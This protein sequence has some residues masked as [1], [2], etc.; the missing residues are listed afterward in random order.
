MST[1]RPRSPSVRGL[2]YR[3]GDG[4]HPDRKGVRVRRAA[5]AV[6]AGSAA[7]TRRLGQSRH[8]VRVFRRDQ[9]DKRRARTPL[10]VTG[11]KSPDARPVWCRMAGEAGRARPAGSGSRPGRMSHSDRSDARSTSARTSGGRPLVATP[12]R[13]RPSGR[14]PS[15]GEQPPPNTAGNAAACS[16][17]DRLPFRTTGARALLLGGL[18]FGLGS[19]VTSDAEAMVPTGRRADSL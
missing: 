10:R 18:L 14:P 13:D 19:S 1:R 9:P 2:R 4:D 3:L 11:T 12:Q 5:P 16:R 7:T 8:R 6:A 15:S 17:S